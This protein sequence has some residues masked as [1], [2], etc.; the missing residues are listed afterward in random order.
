[1]VGGIIGPAVASADLVTAIDQVI[2]VYLRL[3][4]DDELLPATFARIGAAPFKEALYAPRAA[5][6]P[7][8][9]H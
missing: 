8:Y 5:K 9:A 6:E 1:M 4:A 3:R 7:A 2:E